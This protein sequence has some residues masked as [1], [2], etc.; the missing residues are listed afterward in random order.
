MLPIRPAVPIKKHLP[1]F[2]NPKSID[3]QRFYVV[4]AI[5]KYLLDIISP[6]NTL[7]MDFNN[8]VDE[9]S[10]IPLKFMGFP[11][12]WQEYPVFCLKQ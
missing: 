12:D 7:I 1:E 10:S 9:Y 11:E 4:L 5:L 8:L 6:E 3:N 2:H